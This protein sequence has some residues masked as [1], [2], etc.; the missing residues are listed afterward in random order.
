M[1]INNLKKKIQE[2]GFSSKFLA[3]NVLNVHKTEL[4]NWIAGRRKPKT[5]H[6]RKLAKKLRCK[7]SDLYEE[8]SQND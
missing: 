8:R 6:I 5:E 4:S 7:M 3:E 2:S 1:V